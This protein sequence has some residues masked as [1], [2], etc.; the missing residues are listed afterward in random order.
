M[1]KAANYAENLRAQ[2]NLNGVWKYKRLTIEVD[3][4]QIDATIMGKPNTLGNGRTWT[5]LNRQ[6]N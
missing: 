1:G 6:K 5:L 3:G 4:Y 2:A